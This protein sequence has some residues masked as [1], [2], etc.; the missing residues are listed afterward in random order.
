MA[1]T[2]GFKIALNKAI[3]LKVEHTLNIIRVF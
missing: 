2:I 3:Q 1:I